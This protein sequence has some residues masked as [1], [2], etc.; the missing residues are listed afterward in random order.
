MTSI[1]LRQLRYFVAVAEE[2]HF[3]RAAQRLQ[4]AQPGLSHQIKGLERLLGVPLFIRDQRGVEL[5]AAGRALLEHAR[6]LLQLSERAVESARLAVR[7][8]KGL[9]KV[10]T[11]AG[12][13]HALGNELLRLFQSR[14]PDVQVEI[15]PGYGPQNIEELARRALDVAI[16]IAPFDRPEALRY[17]RLGNEE[18]LLAIPEGHPLASLERIPRSD[19]LDEPFLDWPRGMSPTLI[20]HLHLSL[21]GNG[22]PARAHDTG[23]MDPLEVLLAVA[24]GKGIAVAVFPSV[25]DLKIPRVVFRPLEDAPS[26]EY[27]IAWFDNNASPFTPSFVDLARELAASPDPGT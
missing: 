15:H 27:G 24:E 8:K 7:G 9:L 19:L 22:E 18:L 16:V 21:F 23:H 2:L 10:G 26:L 3:G 11:P 5:T 12:G 13:I 1:E 6:L 4:I 14:R 25:A 17:L 20:D